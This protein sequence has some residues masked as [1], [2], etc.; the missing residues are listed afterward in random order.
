VAPLSRR[1]QLTALG[2]NRDFRLLWIGQAGSELGSSVTSLTLPLLTLVMTGSAVLA[3]LTGTVGFVAMWLAQLPAGYIAD[4]F[5]RRRVML[6]CDAARAV[7]FAALG[8]AVLAGIAP[9]W[10]LLG[11][12]AAS[13]FLAIVFGAAESQAMLRIVPA[14]QIPEAV[15]VT[16]ARS[17]AVDMVG[18]AIGGWLLAVGRPVPLLADAT[19]YVVSFGCLR[20]M[21]TPLAADTA[22]SW[23][24]LLPDVGKGWQTLW[25]NRFLRATTVYSTLTNIAV[26]TLL[27]QL[28]LGGGT[29]TAGIGASV[30][31]AAAAGLAGSTAAPLATRRLSLRLLLAGGALVRAG[32]VVLAAAIGGPVPF[33]VAIASVTFLGPMLGASLGAATL[34]AVPPDVLGR[35]SASSAFLASALQP[36]APLI[37]GGLLATLPGAGSQLVLAAAFGLVALAAL[38]LPGLDLGRPAPPTAPATHRAAPT[39]AAHGAGAG[40]GAAQADATSPPLP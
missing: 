20:R 1:S 4:M 6:L 7:L 19:S 17:Y 14:A 3:G 8:T 35:A 40:A 16:Q 38:T 36:V 18:P 13:S 31:L 34:L 9:V 25:H 5:D 26:T 24:R 23:S 28:I 22:P 10:A 37:A 30:S 29:G 12:T 21:R 39:P 32:A 33:A 15:S 2:T 27:Y 11:I